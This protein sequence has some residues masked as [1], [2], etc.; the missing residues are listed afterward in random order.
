M[1]KKVKIGCGGMLTIRFVDDNLSIALESNTTHA[2]LGTSL[3]VKE[4][5]KDTI[6]EVAE[7]LLAITRE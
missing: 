6:M 2:M 1:E 7:A 4:V 3:W 5:T